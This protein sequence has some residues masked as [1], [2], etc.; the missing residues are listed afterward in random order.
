MRMAKR[1]GARASTSSTTFA[2]AMPVPTTTKV[3]R[4]TAW[5]MVALLFRQPLALWREGCLLKPS[6]RRCRQA[7]LGDEITL[8]GPANPHQGERTGE[9]DE[10]EDGEAPR[11][12]ARQLL[13]AAQQAGQEEAAQA[14]GGADDA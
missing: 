6:G 3:G 12:R 2:P 7:A 5:I 4:R 13:H 9:A 10:G 11:E 8:P 1:S 14:A